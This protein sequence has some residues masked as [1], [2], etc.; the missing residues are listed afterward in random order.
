[1]Q[2]TV[3][4]RTPSSTVLRYLPG[5]PGVPGP[6]GATPTLTMGT[7][8][9]LSAGSSPTASFTGSNPYALN[10]GLPAGATGP[11]NTL[12]IGTVSTL[13]AGASATATITGTAPNQTLSLGIP[14]GATGPLGSGNGDVTGAASSVDSNIVLFNGTT[15]KTIKD[16]GL[17]LAALARTANNLSDLASASTARTNLGLGALATLAVVG[18]AQITDA[19]VTNA[20]LANMASGTLRGRVTAGSGVPEDITGAQFRDSVQATGAVIDR[21]YA[22]Y[23]ANANLTTILPADNTVPQNTE[24]TQVLSASLTP[25]STTNRIRARV[26]LWGSPSI[27]Q[28]INAALFTGGA[29]AVQAASVYAYAGLPSPLPFE[30]EYVPG[31]TS[32][33]TVTVRVGPHSASTIRLNGDTASSFFGAGLSACTLVL[34]EI[35]A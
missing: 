13:S 3:R 11:A 8:S 15:G 35:K 21:A 23:T 34:E 16:G 29:S 12:A 2:V 10:L 1:M 9:G 7:V 26:M 5:V 31:S 28:Y 20:K 6:T 17:G 24:G 18:T 22:T 25:K 4:A 30:Y 33:Q 27:D 19:A 14:Q 32:A